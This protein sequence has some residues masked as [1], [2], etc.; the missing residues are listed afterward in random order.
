MADHYVS[1]TGPF[2]L[3]PEWVIRLP[4][5]HGSF[6]LYATIARFADYDTGHA[7]PSRQTLAG[8]LD[9]STDTVDRWL[10]ELEKAGALEITRRKDGSVNQTN[11]YRIIRVSPTAE[12]GRNGTATP[13]RKDAATGGRKDAAQTKTSIDRYSPK[14]IV[15]IFQA[16]L[17]STGR[18]EN[19]TR[20]D[21]K[22]KAIIKKALALYPAAD[23]VDA[24]QGWKQS[25][26]H[27]GENQ[28]GKTYND[29]GL[30]LRDAEHIERFRDL[31]RSASRRG[32]KRTA[33][34][35]DFV[36]PKPCGK[37]EDG[38]MTERDERGRPASRLC[39][40][41]KQPA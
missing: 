41:Q 13:P 36:R 8:R 40:C 10:R 34:P 1:D 3:I 6:R 4:V 2:A 23:L 15:D 32:S 31:Q 11:L 25:A 16:W 18:D 35:Y 19:R 22:R 9:V 29:L 17:D 14:D 28:H 37:C 26:F 21:D 7:F 33:R 20:L 27:R 39:D 12:G 30:L 24:V 38:W 5:S